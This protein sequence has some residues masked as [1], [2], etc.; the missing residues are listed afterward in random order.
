MKQQTIREKAE[1][2]IKEAL[3][4]LTVAEAKSSLQNII[5]RLDNNV[6]ISSIKK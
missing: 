3:K 4:G 5:L 6:V 2:K 1:E